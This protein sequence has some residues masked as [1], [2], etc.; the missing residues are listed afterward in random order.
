MNLHDLYD[1]KNQLMKDILTD[2]SIVELIDD[3]VPIEEAYQMAYKNVYP[4]EYMPET[5]HDGRT[6]VCFDVSVQQSVSKTYLLPTLYIW[7]FVH[8]DKLRLPEG[9]VRS[10][11][12]CSAICDK[13]NGSREY[14]LGELELYSVKPVQIVTDYPGKVMTFHCAEFNVQHDPNRYTPSNRKRERGN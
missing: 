5:I 11:A 6:F 14:G 10:D 2:P 12:I 7:V 9:G 1:Y 3:D 4:L 13:I 8:R